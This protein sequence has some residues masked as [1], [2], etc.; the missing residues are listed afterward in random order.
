MQ[1]GIEE[2]VILV[3]EQDRPIGAMGKMEAHQKGILHRAISVFIVNSKGE[4]LLQ[5]RHSD[6]YHSGGLWSN[7]CCS[8]P[9]PGENTE[10]TAERRLMEEMGL[11]S[12]LDK[13]FGFTYRATINNV[14]IEHEFDHVFIGYSDSVPEVNPIEVKDWKYLSYSEI[15]TEA[16]NAPE[17]FT[18]WFLK[19][20]E[21]VH[22]EIQKSR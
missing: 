18:V 20:M 3:D 4:W 21:R 12:N 22:Q 17:D 15:Q 11:K 13:L 10:Q 7:A 2:Q 8:H 5:Q 14:L 9:R 1:N 19:I 16:K 6:K